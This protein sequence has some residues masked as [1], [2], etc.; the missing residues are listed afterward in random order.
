MRLGDKTMRRAVVATV[1]L[2]VVLGAILLMQDELPP[3]PPVQSSAV[4]LPKD[5]QIGGPFSLV[6]HRGRA[7]SERDYAGRYLLIYFGYTFCPDICPTELQTMGDALD[8]MGEAAESVQPI[9]ITI[10]PERDT[11]ALLADYVGNFHP[12]LVGL[13]GSA[14]QIA[15]A[16]KTYGVFYAKE[17]PA[18]GAAAGEGKDYFM[19]HSSY[20]Y[21]MGP[22][23]RM[24]L[25]LRR[26]AD[27]DEMARQIKNA[28]NGAGS[29]S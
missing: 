29:G 6:D 14:E 2:T 21:L 23:G 13:T 10:D 9:F 1:A 24:R 25:L 12:R 26:G 20:I 16:A 15:R 4:T 7:V 18:D 28:M 5:T 27:P 19:S 17:P 11:V 8:S 3:A 22:D